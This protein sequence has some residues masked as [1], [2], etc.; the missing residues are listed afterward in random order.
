M[1]A[2]AEA[3]EKLQGYAN[4]ISDETEYHVSSNVGR[5]SY[6]TRLEQTVTKLRAKLREESTRVESVRRASYML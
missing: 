1:A 2:T 4:K 5:A 3:L 6:E